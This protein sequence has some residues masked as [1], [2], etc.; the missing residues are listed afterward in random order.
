MSFSPM[1]QH[2]ESHG[3]LPEISRFILKTG[4]KDLLTSLGKSRGMDTLPETIEVQ[5]G[6]MTHFP[7][8]KTGPRHSMELPY[9]PTVDPFSTTPTDRQSY[10]SPT[11]SCLGGFAEEP[12][13][14]EPSGSNRWTCR[15]P[16][17][18]GPAAACFP[19]RFVT[20]AL[21]NQPQIASPSLLGWRP[22]LLGW[23]PLLVGC[24]IP[25]TYPGSP[26]MNIPLYSACTGRRP[27]LP[28]YWNL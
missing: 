3:V 28:G 4:Q 27:K 9:M 6:W 12:A 19:A 15:R 8:Y 16:A 10:G 23:R 14:S 1:A 26:Q 2:R 17:H 24:Y 25:E 21:E 22:W 13:P 11:G 18:D 20:K 5:K 7:L